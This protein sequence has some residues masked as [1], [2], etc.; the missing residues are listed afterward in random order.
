MTITNFLLITFCG[1]NTTQIFL[2]CPHTE[3]HLKGCGF[4]LP[5]ITTAKA[6]YY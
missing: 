2:T 3:H 6:D 1:T 4:T 5:T